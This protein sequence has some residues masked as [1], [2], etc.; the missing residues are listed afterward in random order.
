MRRASEMLVVCLTGMAVVAT[1]ITCAPDG[2]L[3]GAPPGAPNTDLA[4]ANGADRGSAKAGD[5]ITYSVTVTNKG[6]LAATGVFAGDTLAS[7]ETYLTSSVSSGSYNSGNGLW[8]IGA[9]GVGAT[10]T[11]TLKA[12]PQLGASGTLTNRAGVISTDQND[13]VLTNNIAASLVTV[14]TTAPSVDVAIT[15]SADQSS[16]T[17]GSTVTWT[18]VV[19]NKGP[20][21]ADG[22]VAGDTLSAGAGY[23]SHT[24]TVGAYVPSS[25]VWTIGRL[26]VGSQAVLTLKAIV[27]SGTGGTTLTNKARATST[28]VDSVPANN[29]VASSV[30]VSGSSGSAS[31]DSEPAY[32]GSKDVMVYQDNFDSYTSATDILNNVGGQGAHITFNGIGCAPPSCGAVGTIDDPYNANGPYNTITSA[33]R[34]GKA[35]RLYYPPS[36]SPSV[37]N[38]S[39][40]LALVNFANQAVGKDAIVQYWVRATPAGPFSGQ[41]GFK[42]IELWPNI[43][44]SV[45][46]YGNV[47]S[48]R[49]QFSLGYSTT[50]NAR[51][52]AA[53]T[54][55]RVNPNSQGEFGE[56]AYPSPSFTDIADGNWHSITVE[57]KSNSTVGAADA[58]A[59]MWVDHIEIVDVELPSEGVTPPG[60]QKVWCKAGDTRVLIVNDGITRIS[61]GSVEFSVGGGSVPAITLDFD[62]FQYWYKGP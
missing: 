51:A 27:Q 37:Q 24:A 56:Q 8:T 29:F 4:I 36:A 47:V 48:G 30:S 57:F 18:V 50:V 19:T 46:S 7:I 55:W 6:P 16:P 45:N 39:Q 20:V 3:M 49:T 5:T 11:L 40:V 28:T 34:S 13:S 21:A 14:T 22:I 15:N 26:G 9:L 25:G 41:P 53:T 2:T 17:I 58:I 43:D 54:F 1:V 52:T 10:A 61:L 59:R 42:W 23:L 38:A 62:D 31:S 44:P 35:F 12:T 33:G 32:N 60:A